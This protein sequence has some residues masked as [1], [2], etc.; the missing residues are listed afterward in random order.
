[1]RQWRP[2]KMPDPTVAH[3]LVMRL[4]DEMNK[5]QL[6]YLDVTERAGLSKDSLDD[7]RY[8]R[9]PRLDLICAAFGTL[10]LELVARPLRERREPYEAPE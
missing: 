4:F 2:V 7:W 6:G 9:R 10:G 5:Q 3:P 1:M 8:G